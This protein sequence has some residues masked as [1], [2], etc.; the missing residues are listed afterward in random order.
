MRILAILLVLVLAACNNA[1]QSSPEVN[2]SQSVPDASDAFVLPSQP[3]ARTSDSMSH[4]LAA[5]R[6]IGYNLR[7]SEMPASDEAATMTH[8]SDNGD[9]D[10]LLQSTV[11][12]FNVLHLASLTLD[13]DISGNNNLAA[14]RGAFAEG[15]LKIT[16]DDEV[17]DFLTTIPEQALEPE[18][19]QTSSAEAEYEL[20]VRRTA[21]SIQ[22]TI[23]NITSSSPDDS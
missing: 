19:M 22:L 3:P 2:S 10:I 4:M 13:G 12:D 6:E 23:V 5:F 7:T 11:G 17:V 21:D 8:T 1:S 16:D 18:T 20:S 15:V 14:A 9:I